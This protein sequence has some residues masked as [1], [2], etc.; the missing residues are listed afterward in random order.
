MKTFI[1][2]ISLSEISTPKVTID[3][4]L[5]DIKFYLMDG[6]VDL[7]TRIDLLNSYYVKYGES[8]C[9]EFI[10]RITTLYRFAGT[11]ILE[12]YLYEICKCKIPAFIK[13]I[14]AK[15]LCYFDPKNEIG[16]KALNII[17]QDMND[18]PTPSKIDA[19]CLLMCHKTYKKQSLQYFCNIINNTKLDCDY[20]Y[21]TILSLENKE[22]LSKTYFLRESAIEFFKERKNRTLYRILAGQFLIQK[23]KPTKKTRDNIE[24]TLM[25]FAQDPDLD[26]NLRADSADAILHLGSD[27]NKITAREIIMMLGRKDGTV[28]TIFDNA[29]NV[30]VDEIEESV[31]KGL[32]FLA[33]IVMKTVSGTP[34][35][36]SIDFK[37]RI[38]KETSLGYCRKRET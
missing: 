20:R 4:D 22:V 28:K 17:C 24:L 10:S 38:C 34:G 31:L 36:P 9:L 12:K 8:E 37:K 1:K 32:E 26:Y 7:A 6:S 23:C 25:S 3:D 14:V 21:K 5:N 13:I 29:Q 35:T 18:V 27:E 15:S 33:S 2:N 19:V 16:Y 11:K 30:H